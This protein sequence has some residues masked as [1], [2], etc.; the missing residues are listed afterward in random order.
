MFKK[1][2]YAKFAKFSRT[3]DI[4]EDEEKQ[5]DS[6]NTIEALLADFC[7]TSSLFSLESILTH[8]TLD[9]RG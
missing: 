3:R 6:W 8:S 7:L 9:L 1:Y 4:Q 5:E 2:K